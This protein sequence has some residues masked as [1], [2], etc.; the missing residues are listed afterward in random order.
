MGTVYLARD[1]DLDRD[2]A[3]KFI[4]D[5]RAAD[6]NA[7]R[8]LI[9]EAR[10]AAALD[11]PNICAVHDVIVE[12][13]GHSFIVMQYVE[14][15]TVAARLRRGPLETRQ[16]FLVAADVAAALSAAHKRGI[17][18][19][20]VKPQNIIITPS[21]RAKLL[22]FGIARLDDPVASPGD[23]TATNL[24]GPGRAAGTPV[25][26][27]PEQVQQQPLDGRA[28][29]FSLGSVVYECLTGRRPFDGASDAEIY[30]KIL[31]EHPP[32][33][34]AIRP[35]LSEQE[36]ELCR[37]LLA[38]HPDDRFSS[39][40][41]LLGA[42]R[43]LAPDTAHASSGAHRVP[44]ATRSAAA[45]GTLRLRAVQIA[46]LV[47]GVLVAAGVWR[48]RTAGVPP[49]APPEAERWYV[50][51]TQLIH[52]GAYHSGRLALEEAVKIF[53]DYALAYARLAEAYAELDDHDRARRALLTMDRLVPNRS[54]LPIED[55]LRLD[56]IR[57]LALQDASGAVK[58]YADLAERRP[59]DAALW[60][61]LGRA[62]E[63]A[64]SLAVARTSYE[65]SIAIDD[66]YAAAHLRRATTLMQQTDRDE[67]L[68]EFDEAERL[69]RA[70]SNVEGETEAL[71]RRGGF[72][73]T[74]GRPGEA[75]SALE[76]ARAVALG[77]KNRPQDLRARLRLS[78]VTLLEGRL[79][80]ALSAAESAIGEALAH[81]LDTVAAEGLVELAYTL[82]LLPRP[83]DA[84]A[85][86]LRAIQLAEK[87]G[88]QRVLA[89]ARLQHAAVLI[90]LGRPEEALARARSGVESARGRGYRRSELTGLSI[91]ARAH[92]LLAQYADARA[93]AGEVLRVAEEVKDEAQMVQALENLAGQSAATGALPE[94]L[95]YR[96][97]RETI[98]RAHNNRPQLAFD[99]TNRAE[100]LIRLGRHD[101]AERA[102]AEVDAGIAAGIDVYKTRVR[103]VALLRALS[104]ALTH[105]F[106]AASRAAASVIRT[107]GASPDGT[108][109]WAAGLLAYADAR[110]AGRRPAAG[111][112]ATAASREGLYWE[113]AAQS[114]AGDALAVSAAA[115]AALAQAPNVVSYEYEW[116][117]AAL[118]A[119]AARRAGAAD[120]A[121]TLSA[122]A[123]QALDRLRDAWKEHA[124]TYA[125]IP[126]VAELIRE[127]GLRPPS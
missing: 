63:A 30:I 69:Y 105:R 119:A 10:A 13:E 4:A 6:E 53:P 72:L 90:E 78:V 100:L 99:L 92:E 29:L 8:R 65:R 125:A 49:D 110:S 116:R 75:R 93:I 42:L 87:V 56:A 32:A 101:E 59:D 5:D 103:R 113:L 20:D 121:Q 111:P 85:Q 122:R 95:D 21:G 19:R 25:Y 86:V 88:A 7:R 107:S 66:Q 70:A 1:L 54:R 80:E 27:S 55:R 114:H 67:A 102:L 14:G 96:V 73:V 83:G 61:D 51:G 112:A 82:M 79:P 33:V 124:R 89:R 120:R 126:H 12:P 9:R 62:Q 43:V 57:A 64:S 34:S 127:A 97:R 48:W 108:T 39:A 37:R 106:D 68:K 81:D 58:A 2:V 40:D 98:N 118:G 38:K 50:K 109:R 26:M 16:A 115:I 60:L 28:D 23:S 91:M 94:A 35:E 45:A 17:I 74:I 46:V 104:A 47:V 52:D 3:I 117:V 11:H 31:Q 41:E 24:T 18:H 77:V 44:R 84:E 71:L 123:Q 36:D 15:E 22:D 76:R